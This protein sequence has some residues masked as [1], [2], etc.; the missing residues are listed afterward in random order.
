MDS[1]G[2]SLQI[3][4]LG[5]LLSTILTLC[6][7]FAQNFIASKWIAHSLFSICMDIRRVR[8]IFGL[9]CFLITILVLTISLLE[10]I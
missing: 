5:V 9:G 3:F 8:G 10:A 6:Q 2:G 4:L 7:V 1:I